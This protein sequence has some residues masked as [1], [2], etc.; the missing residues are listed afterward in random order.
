MVYGDLQFIDIII[1]AGIAAFLIYRLRN[2]LGKRGG[3]ENKQNTNI[4]KSDQKTTNENKLPP[5][6]KENEQ[7]LSTVYENIPNFEIHK[8]DVHKLICFLKNKHL[9]LRDLG[10]NLPLSQQTT[11]LRNYFAIPNLSIK[12]ISFGIKGLNYIDLR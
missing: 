8:N 10:P 7:K 6:L 11:R 12:K 3:Y 5:Q 4:E 1:F 9:I 2:V